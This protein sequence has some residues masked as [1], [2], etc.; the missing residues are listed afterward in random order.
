MRSQAK[1]LLILVLLGVAVFASGTTR[2]FAASYPKPVGNVNDFV[3]VLSTND[4][5]NLNALVGAVLEQTG[6]TFAIAIVDNTGGESLEYYAA[7]LYEEWGIGA[8]GQDEGLL[9]L[10]VMDDR[11]LKA[12]VGYGL[13][14]I[15]TDRRAGECL[16]LMTPYF[17]DGEFGKG[18]Y[19]GLMRA[20]EYVAKDKGVVLDVT[21][22]SEDYRDVYA[23]R[24]NPVSIGWLGLLLGAPLAAVGL[25]ISR[26]YRCPRCKSRL[27]VVDRVIQRATYETG[28]IAAKVYHCPRCGYHDERNYRTGPLSRPGS[29]GI[30]TGPGPFFGGGF[31]GRGGSGRGGGISGPRGFGGGRSGG[32][33]ASRKW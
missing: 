13:E 20:A 4:E 31:W 10:L 29:G 30:P 15:I 6:V 26:R 23:G 21:A 8:K 27:S 5:A 25:L 32:G 17:K 28:G 33:G 7:N 14:P 19:A 9:I 12:E 22:V 18:L 3:G 1:R 16:D 24:R 2:A 11:D